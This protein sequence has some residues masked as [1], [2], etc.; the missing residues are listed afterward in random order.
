M[1][2]DSLLGSSL[3]QDAGEIALDSSRTVRDQ[4]RSAVR[5]RIDAFPCGHPDR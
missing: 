5:W 2:S 3:R 1:E 4:I